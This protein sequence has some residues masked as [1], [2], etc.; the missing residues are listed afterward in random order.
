MAKAKKSQI[1]CES[2]SLGALQEKFRLGQS[3]DDGI[4]RKRGVSLFSIFGVV[5]FDPKHTN[6]NIIRV[7]IFFSQIQLS[8]NV[9]GQFRNYK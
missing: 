2:V 5:L 6:L 1:S 4:S 8:V 9:F 3:K 7:Y